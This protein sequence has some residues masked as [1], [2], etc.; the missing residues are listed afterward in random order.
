MHFTFLSVEAKYWPQTFSHLSGWS[1]HYKGIFLCIWRLFF[2][3]CE[4]KCIFFFISF[5][6][7]HFFLLHTSYRIHFG[8]IIWLFVSLVHHIFLLIISHYIYLNESKLS[9]ENT[10]RAKITLAAWLR[11]D[12]FL[13]LLHLIFCFVFWLWWLWLYEWTNCVQMKVNRSHS[14]SAKLLLW[15]HWIREG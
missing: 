10:E 4:L 1:A 9:K 12:C 13:I 3:C 11:I 15:N 8:L 2:Y 5:Y 14:P 6:S 7:F